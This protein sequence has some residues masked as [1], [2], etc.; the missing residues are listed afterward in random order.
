MT[1]ILEFFKKE[2]GFLGCIVLIVVVLLLGARAIDRDNK[3]LR[4]ERNFKLSCLE[5]RY[6][7]V[8]MEPRG[9]IICYDKNAKVMRTYG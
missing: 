5:D 3:D 7:P 6:F 9:P 2:W 4:K 1:K 8:Q